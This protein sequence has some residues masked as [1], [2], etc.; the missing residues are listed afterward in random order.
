MSVSS[1]ID[2]NNKICSQFLPEAPQGPPGPPWGVGP[3]GP[4]G[5]EG[6][7]GPQGPIGPS[8]SDLQFAN[9][10]WQSTN[11]NPNPLSPG[12]AFLLNGPLGNGLLP[13]NPSSGITKNDNAFCPLVPV[14]APN[15]AGTEVIISVP[16]VYEIKYGGSFN[17]F[18]D[19]EENAVISIGLARGP[20]VAGMADIPSSYVTS[21]IQLPIGGDQF[22]T[23][24]NMSG[25][26]I[27]DLQQ[28]LPQSIMLITNKDAGGNLNNVL[29]SSFTS[30][31]LTINQIA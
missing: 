14:G 29:M 30:V 28:G 18:N 13:P 1:I 31:Y 12:N 2:Q 7:Q 24:I 10:Y 15:V 16:G 3:E 11:P 19:G 5:P 21:N 26:Y 17:G 23:L 6:P 8:F 25:S 9:F 20:N 27:M 4:E 22:T